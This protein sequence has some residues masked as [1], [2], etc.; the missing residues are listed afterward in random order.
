VIGTR[1]ELALIKSSLRLPALA[2][3]LKK[4]QGLR[5][6]LRCRFARPVPR[7]CAAELIAGQKVLHKYNIFCSLV[8][9]AVKKFK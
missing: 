1:S 3:A 6:G 8:I 2:T 5:L 7:P 4:F 9:G